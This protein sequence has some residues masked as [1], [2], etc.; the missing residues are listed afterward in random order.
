MY[1]YGI[2]NKQTNKQK[3][4]QKVTMHISLLHR[5]TEENN[6]L[7]IRAHYPLPSGAFPPDLP[8]WKPWDRQFPW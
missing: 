1:D 8:L 5:G 4:K 2:K 6:A 7:L 3:T